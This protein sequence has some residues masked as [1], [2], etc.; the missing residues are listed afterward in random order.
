MSFIMSI[1]CDIRQEIGVQLNTERPAVYEDTA[2][3]QTRRVAQ[4]KLMFT[5][6]R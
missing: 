5:Q 3:I 4:N 6:I 2:W 1:D